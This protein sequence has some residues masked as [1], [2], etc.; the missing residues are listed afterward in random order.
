MSHE[1]ASAAD[2][3]KRLSRTNRPHQ[4]P[5]SFA[6][7][8]LWAF[9]QLEGPNTT[10]NIPL[11]VRLTGVLDA[12]AL[13]KSLSDVVQ[14]HESLR[15]VIDSV[16]GQPVQTVLTDA[17]P[18]LVVTTIEN[19]QLPDA[20]SAVVNYTF[21]LSGEIPLRAWLWQT[22]PHEHVFVIMLHH[23]AADGWSMAPLMR[24][25]SLAYT[26]RQQ[27][28]SPEFVELPVQYADY[29]LWQRELLGS[30]DDPNSVVTRQLDYWRQI[31][32][33]VPQKMALPT[34]RPRTA[35]IAHRGD[36]VPLEV[37]GST[38]TQ[39]LQ[40]AR[41]QNVTVFMVLNAALA[42]ALSRM[43]AGDDIVI[44][45]ALSGRAEEALEDLVG[46]FVNTVALR[47]NLSGNPTFTQLLVRVRDAQLGAHS[48]ADVPF[49]QVMDSLRG[50][51]SGSRQT[52]LQVMMVLQNN[53]RADLELPGLTLSQPADQPRS[54]AAKFDLTI[55]MAETS[56]GGDQN[57]G[58]TGRIQYAVDVFDRTTVTS[59][60]DR[61]VRVIES[62]VREPETP[63]SQIEV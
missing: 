58:L 10:Y 36:Q 46:F 53:A 8:R 14:R 56:G 11:M 49:E 34:D 1:L 30:E 42:V 18:E 60:A 55:S 22:G 6:Q 19:T 41:Q 43:G 28:H 57:L 9:D 23:I 59:L 25:L 51:R 52:L 13:Q 32:R 63:I 50:E 48:H 47:T 12:S 4:L 61:F 20:L 17:S 45:T 24:D 15:T 44:G 2:A 35:A 27:G 3:R 62:V 26:A 16:D 39:L 21:D 5:L 54:A 40:L 37:A 38:Y 31:L 29:T 7:W 33:D